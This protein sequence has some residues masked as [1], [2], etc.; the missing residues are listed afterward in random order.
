MWNT[1][2]YICGDVCV[3]SVS[4]MILVCNMTLQKNCCFEGLE[5]CG[6][7]HWK[8]SF[9]LKNWAMCYQ[10]NCFI[11]NSYGSSISRKCW[12]NYSVM[13]LMWYPQFKHQTTSFVDHAVDV[14]E[15]YKVSLQSSKKCLHNLHNVINEQ[16]WVSFGMHSKSKV[17]PRTGHEDPEGGRGI[18]LL[19][20]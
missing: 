7:D 11:E 16:W 9:P 8:I 2:L 14:D 19:F 3:L 10:W 17:H 15:L 13:R 4:W 12:T 5:A 6:Q 20:L 18:G 1:F